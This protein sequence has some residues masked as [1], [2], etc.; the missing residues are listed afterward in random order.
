METSSRTVERRVKPTNDERGCPSCEATI[1]QSGVGVREGTLEA[2]GT[3][4]RAR[5]VG[6]RRL[7]RG[8][9]SKTT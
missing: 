2:R 5:H 9:R 1:S 7:L 3:L 8:S 4:R 6:E